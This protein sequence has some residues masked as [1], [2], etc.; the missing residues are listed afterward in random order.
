MLSLAATGTLE[1]G[2]VAHQ[3]ELD[4]THTL[5]ESVAV[6][7]PLSVAGQEAVDQ[8][9]RLTRGI[10]RLVEGARGA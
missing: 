7:V 10:A 1:V 8:Q 9:Q 3:F 6:E 5:A 2:A 4:E